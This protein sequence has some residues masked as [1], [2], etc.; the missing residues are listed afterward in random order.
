VV[1]G[2]AAILALIIR[3][4]CFIVGWAQ[5]SRREEIRKI[6]YAEAK[7]MLKN[8]MERWAQVPAWDTGFSEYCPSRDLFQAAV[9]KLADRR[10]RHREHCLS[11]AKKE[12][13]EK[14][15]K[16]KGKKS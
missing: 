9:K 16:K 12:R 5:D 6:A 13:I 11:E 7:K 10:I 1:I 8:E 14:L 4:I 3:F 2:A 15:V